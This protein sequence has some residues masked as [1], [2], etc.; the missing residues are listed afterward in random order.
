M[1]TIKF[2]SF[3]FNKNY[4]G[5]VLVGDLNCARMKDEN[6]SSMIPDIKY[7]KIGKWRWIWMQFSP[8]PRM[9]PLESCLILG[10]NWLV[11]RELG[12]FQAI[13]KQLQK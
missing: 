2:S 13:M 1:S 6:R 9:I 7:K 8:Q 5:A 11:V 4:Q 10:T 12:F 3:G